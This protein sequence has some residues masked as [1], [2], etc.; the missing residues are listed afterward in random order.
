MIYLISANGWT[1]HPVSANV[2]SPRLID[3]S[4]DG[5]TLL[6]HSI[7]EA[8]PG[9]ALFWVSLQTN[10]MRVLAGSDGL[11]NGHPSPDGH[12]IAAHLDGDTRLFL[13]D[14]DRHSTRLL[15]TCTCVPSWSKDGTLYF[16][17]I[18]R[19][20]DG[21]YRVNISDGSIER[22]APAP[23]F[24]LVG[25]WGLWGGTAPDG[26]LL[27]LRDASTRDI[28]ALDAEMP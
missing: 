3:W 22:V 23:G 12:Y 20:D 11:P 14:V 18:G 10:E 24:P 28:Y 7:T 9:G 1:P 27:L 6:V 15:A 8:H 13:Y 21:I 19:P 26:S 4:A 17:R 2:P 25:A 16:G 5:G